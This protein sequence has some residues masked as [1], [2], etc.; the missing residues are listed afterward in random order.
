MRC[1]KLCAESGYFVNA[2]GSN[3][4]PREHRFFSGYMAGKGGAGL[5]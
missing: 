5:K 1:A 3:R 2:D 4:K